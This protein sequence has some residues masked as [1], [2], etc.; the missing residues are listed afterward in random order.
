MENIEWT[1][2]LKYQ[3]YSKWP[4]EYQKRLK[5]RVLNSFF[6]MNYH[7][8]P[9]SG[10]L[11]DPN[12][13]SFFNGKWHL[14]YQYFPMGAIHGL[15][16]W[17]HL[18]SSDLI[19]WEEQGYALI[20]DNQYDNCGV[21]S[22]SAIELNGKL[23][24]FYT[25]NVRTEEWKRIPYQN[26][27][28]L[29]TENNISKIQTP[30]IY[31]NE[32][33]TEHFRD[34]MLFNY[35]D[36]VYAVVGAQ[37]KMLSGRIALYEMREE[38]LHE[39]EYHGN[40]NFT[41]NNLGHMIECPN[42]VFINNIPVLIFCPQG[43]NR[44]YHFYENVY[45]NV[46]MIGKS[47]DPQDCSITP[48]SNLVNIDEGFDL[49]ATQAF[50]S[51]DGRVLSISW[52]G[53]P[54]IAYPT[55]SEGWS[56][57]LSLVKELSIIDGK[58]IQYPVEETK[59]LRGKAVFC[60]LIDVIKAPE[61]H[62]YELETEIAANK[63]VKL[64]LFADSEKTKGLFLTIDTINGYLV[65]DRKKSGISF[66][67]EFGYTR[68]IRIAKHKKIKLNLFVDNSVI[69]IY[70]N[71]GEK[72][73]TSRIFPDITQEYIYSDQYLPTTVWPLGTTRLAK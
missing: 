14:F 57:C 22:G 18:T 32:N 52:I 27:A 24:L 39:W 73:I 25:G 63:K 45:P 3:P 69:E 26:G 9:D 44:D 64:T 1:K 20:P 53:L 56:G 68:T 35:Q 29:D 55:D 17:F 15:K 34:P 7:I 4:T 50:N 66:A 72:T 59:S 47:F 33:F 30:L 21:Y 42:L 71:K 11:N 70:V 31:P 65:V 43:L 58:L 49:Y 13:F 19:N 37:D 2:Q 28:W 38:N 16:S 8:Q 60:D 36:K 46:Y 5:K 62:S 48:N 40:L 6:R 67:K 41:D 51:P 23:L 54:D 61:K 12:G 10:L